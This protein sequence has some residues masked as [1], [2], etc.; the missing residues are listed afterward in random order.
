LY[1]LSEQQEGLLSQG[2]D[3]ILNQAIAHR[4]DPC[5]ALHITHEAVNLL[6]FRSAVVNLLLQ[7]STSAVIL[8]DAINVAIAPF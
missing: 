8:L 7:Q 1:H 5:L 2:A 3:F 6:G 4:A